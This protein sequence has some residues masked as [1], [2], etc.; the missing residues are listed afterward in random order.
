MPL[1]GYTGLYRQP[2]ADHIT[3]G[4]TIYVMMDTAHQELNILLLTPG[5]YLE[6]FRMASSITFQRINLFVPSMD[7]LFLSDVFRLVIDLQKIKKT[8]RWYYPDKIT[9]KPPNLL[10]E[11]AQVL[12]TF[13]LSK[14]IPGL[15]I[16]FQESSKDENK[17]GLYDFKVYDGEDYD[18]FSLF[19]TKEKMDD[20]LRSKF[21][22]I[23]FAYNSTF[24][25]GCTVR[26]LSEYN[27]WRSHIVPNNYMSIEEFREAQHGRYGT[28]YR[29]VF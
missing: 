6:V 23:H 29:I 11:R 17:A 28:A 16:N 27:S 8:V 26:E 5:A 14:A 15:T 22:R 1:F 25:G 13:F 3:H 9:V 2:F 4:D 12:S 18:C 20:L 21:D 19:M 24:Y 7:A 10:F